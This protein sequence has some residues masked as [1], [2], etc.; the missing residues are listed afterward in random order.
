[1]RGPTSADRF[2]AFAS[3]RAF[4][5]RRVVG[6]Q[7]FAEAVLDLGVPGIERNFRVA[8]AEAVAGLHQVRGNAVEPGR[9]LRVGPKPGPVLID[10][11]EGF[12]SEIGGVFRAREEADVAG[13]L[14]GVWGGDDGFSSGAEAFDQGF[15]AG[16]GV[17]EDAVRVQE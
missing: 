2:R 7:G 6:R 12:L 16:E 17:G 15:A 14:G 3:L 13:A 9:E 4:A 5:W 1:M 8:R 10:A 11:D